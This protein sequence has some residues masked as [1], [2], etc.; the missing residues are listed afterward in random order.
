MSCVR[1]GESDSYTEPLDAV[2]LKWA[3]K[4]A[5]ETYDPIHPPD[6][7]DKLAWPT[8]CL[9]VEGSDVGEAETQLDFST[10]PSTW[11]K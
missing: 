3:G 9:D 11:E 6:T 7:L 4:D 1:R 5:T 10:N 2:I 8:S